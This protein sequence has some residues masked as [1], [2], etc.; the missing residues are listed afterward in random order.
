MRPPT[1]PWLLANTGLI[2][3]LTAACFEG[4]LGMSIF[5]IG[6]NTQNLIQLMQQRRQSS[7]GSEKVTQPGGLA[8]AQPSSIGFE[9]AIGAL[10]PSGS[11]SSGGSLPTP[12]VG[13]GGSGF[14]STGP[15]LPPI[16]GAPISP[17]S[18]PALPPIGGAPVSPLPPPVLPPISGTPIDG[19]PVS[20]PSPW[21]S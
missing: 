19:K 16:S 10:Q 9:S 7:N 1:A 20:P 12:S 21:I 11:A 8:G 17:P 5:G 18:S 6:G 14:S 4:D 3:E 13:F 15:T 2:V